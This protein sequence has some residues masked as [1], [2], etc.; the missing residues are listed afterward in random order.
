[1]YG[2]N[3]SRNLKIQLNNIYLNIILIL[4]LNATLALLEIDTVR[5]H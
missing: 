1:M 2:D 4:F 3:K 5:L